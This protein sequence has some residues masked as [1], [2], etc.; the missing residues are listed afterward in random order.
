MPLLAIAEARE[1][2]REEVATVQCSAY[3]S[4]RILACCSAVII[5]RLQG[6]ATAAPERW[7]APGDFPRKPYNTTRPQEGGRLHVR[8]LVGAQCGRARAVQETRSLTRARTRAL[9]MAMIQTSFGLTRFRWCACRSDRWRSAR[10]HLADNKARPRSHVAQIANGQAQ[11]RQVVWRSGASTTSE[12]CR[13]PTGHP[14][15][16]VA[17]EPDW[18][19]PLEH[20]GSHRG[21]EGSAPGLRLAR[22]RV[23]LL[24]VGR[25]ASRRLRRGTPP[26]SWR[27]PRTRP[28]V[29]P[30][31]L[32]SRAAI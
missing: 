31:M 26:R 3:K 5:A 24:R 15:E 22:L 16:T 4:R 32:P 9:V 11:R 28:G 20:R 1:Q 18:L 12:R 23:S 14:H 30:R 8:R 19:G 27:R 25:H 2:S 7:K 10:R 6:Y 17:Q 13:A 21:A 29:G